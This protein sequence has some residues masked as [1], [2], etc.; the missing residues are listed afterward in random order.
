MYLEHVQ[1]QQ[2]QQ[3]E[4]EEEE[5]VLLVSFPSAAPHTFLRNLHVQIETE[6]EIQS[7]RLEHETGLP[8][9]ALPL[10][11]LPPPLS[12]S[13][14]WARS[15][16]LF[17]DLEQQ[18]QEEPPQPGQEETK[19]KKDS[20][21]HLRFSCPPL[22]KSKTRSI[23]WK[24]P[25]VTVYDGQTFEYFHWKEGDMNFKKAIRGTGKKEGEVV[26]PPYL[27]T[28][29]HNP[30]R[31]FQSRV[32]TARMGSRLALVFVDSSFKRTVASAS[33][34]LFLHKDLIDLIL[35]FSFDPLHLS[36]V[37]LQETPNLILERIKKDAR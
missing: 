27:R 36:F 13:H 20:Y 1:Q 21:V 6:F 31:K 15:A 26:A 28:L 16:R 9:H 14:K 11:V 4:E 10:H 8:V 37:P 17:L 35:L 32:E 33:P 24:E 30:E 2:Q 19:G 25:L 5:Q 23:Q 34:L 7:Y 12:L 29:P 18:P 22:S 3:Q